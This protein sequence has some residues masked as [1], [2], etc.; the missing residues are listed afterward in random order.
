MFQISMIR[1]TYVIRCESR[2]ECIAWVNKLRM[3]KASAIRESLGHAPLSESVKKVNQIA[4]KLFNQR[5]EKE[6]E[7]F[8][9]EEGDN[10]IMTVD[11]KMNLLSSQWRSDA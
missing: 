8:S 6:R 5:I 1:K 7:D 2:A 9:R 4:Q 11:T 10:Q 3:R